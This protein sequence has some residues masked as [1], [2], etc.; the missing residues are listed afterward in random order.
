MSKLHFKNNQSFT[1]VELLIVIGILAIL[2]AAIIIVLNP[3]ELLKQAR[4][5]KRI[6]DLS[7]LENNINISQALA[8]NISLGTA[9]TVYVS[10]AD[11]T[12]SSCATLSLPSLPAGYSYA[13]VTESNLHNT[14]GTG[15]IP[16]NFQDAALSGVIQLSTLPTDPIN[17]TSTGL[18]YTYTP[19]GSYELT[20]LLESSEK[21]DAAINDGGMFPGVFQTG[22]HINLTPG[23]RDNGLVGYWPFDEGTG[24]IAY[25]MSGNGNN[26]TLAKSPVWTS[27]CKVGGCLDCDGGGVTVLTTHFGSRAG[28]VVF[29][30]KGNGTVRD[31]YIFTH[32]NG[33][34]RLY[35]RAL[36]ATRILYGLDDATD[37]IYI[38]PFETQ[39]NFY[40]YTYDSP[41][42][43]VYKNGTLIDSGTY[44][45]N[46]EIIFGTNAYISANNWE[47][48]GWVDDVRIYNRT[49][50]AAEIQAI[51][52]ATK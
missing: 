40:V 25:D 18:Y 37:S 49:L 12:S 27:D 19:G 36:D 39:W 2:T 28:S 1:L 48:P 21:A 11:D 33:G 10:I 51:Y 52:N 5:S 46:G 29:W 31:S 50:S 16:I 4:D 13:C 23:L 24:S 30:A 41:S 32:Y 15:W 3:A 26:G 7:G 14:D 9:S 44:N 6:Q 22:T 8:P 38:D 20:S 34:E 35:I 47:F 45:T 43:E 42:Y 17:A